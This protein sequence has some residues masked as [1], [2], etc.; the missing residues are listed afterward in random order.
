MPGN[1]WRSAN[2]GA[3]E[4]SESLWTRLRRACCFSHGDEDL[5]SAKPSEATPLL[6]PPSPAKKCQSDSDD[7]S[8]Y[9]RA[10]FLGDITSRVAALGGHIKSKV[11]GQSWLHTW[12][13]RTVESPWFDPVILVVVVLNAVVV[14]IH[15]DHPE[16][17]RYAEFDAIN[18]AFNVVYTFEI[19]CKVWVYGWRRF[20]AQPYNVFTI[21]ITLAVWVEVCVHLSIFVF[22]SRRWRAYISTDVVQVLQLFRVWK[23]KHMFKEL[24][25]IIDTFVAS[26]R[27]VSWVLVL[28]V[29]CFFICACVATVFVGRQDFDGAA[30]GHTGDAHNAERMREIKD[31]FAS[32]QGSMFTLFELMVIEGWPDYVRPFLAAHHWQYVVFFLAFVFVS[33]FFLLNLFAAIVVDN[34]LL[35]QRKADDHSQLEAQLRHRELA[36]SLYGRLRELKG[37]EPFISLEDAKHWAETDKEVTEILR[38]LKWHREHFLA[39]VTVCDYDCNDEVPLKSLKHIFED[40]GSTLSTKNYVKFQQHVHHRVDRVDEL[41]Q[42]VL[43]AAASLGTV[44]SRT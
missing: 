15:I 5:E 6:L 25:V 41:M 9:G 29:T 23:V 24:E 44:R 14:G 16:L 20:V 32:V 36:G 35:T 28:G 2:W 4:A 21:C 34:M 1:P 22:V 19:V 30:G 12:V 31:S 7:E 11:D 40:C 42:M 37:N 33:N 26:L 38:E 17:F 43:H 8:V 13:R 39:L 10:G 27:A 3:P 18:T